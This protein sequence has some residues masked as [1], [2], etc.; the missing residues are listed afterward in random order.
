MIVVKFLLF[1]LLFFLNVL[2]A[3][4]VKNLAYNIASELDQIYNIDKYIILSYI[5]TESNFEP[6]A[7]SLKTTKI[8]FT[9]KLFNHLKIKNVADKK[10]ISI[11]PK[12]TEQAE[13]AYQIIK[14]NKTRL[15]IENYDLGIMQ[16]NTNN[17]KRW[18]ADEREIYLNMAKNMQFGAVIIRSC[19]DELKHKTHL[20][21]IIECYNRGNNLKKLNTSSKKYLAQFMRNYENFIKNK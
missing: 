10:Y 17:I 15:G 12:N 5:K 14:D 13:I 11:Y 20:E 6:Y 21:N 3:Q 4:N 8:D 9:K 1:S 7:I 18:G 2:H 16:I 19:Y